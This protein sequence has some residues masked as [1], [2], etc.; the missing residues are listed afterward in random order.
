MLQIYCYDSLLMLN[1]LLE[2]LPASFPVWHMA[3]YPVDTSQSA[4]ILFSRFILQQ[5]SSFY[6]TAPINS[7]KQA[8]SRPPVKASVNFS[9]LSGLMP[10]QQKLFISELSG[11][12]YV[13]SLLSSCIFLETFWRDSMLAAQNVYF[14]CPDSCKCDLSQGFPLTVW[15]P[16]TP[17][18][19]PWI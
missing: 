18:F 12:K 15:P 17:Q 14:I 4:C 2:Y 13:S 16:N 1:F 9:P 7:L 6:R 11:K 3:K 10:L 19:I 8:T 5:A